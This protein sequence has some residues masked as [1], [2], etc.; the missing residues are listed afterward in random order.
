MNK[1]LIDQ[2]V[3]ALQYCKDIG[4]VSGV[5]YYTDRINQLKEEVQR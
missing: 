2:Y 3:D 4:L 1:F 5:Y